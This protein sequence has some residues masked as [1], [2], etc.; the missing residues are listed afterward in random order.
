MSAGVAFAS[1]GDVVRAIGSA[2]EVAFAAYLLNPTGSVARGLEAAAD[3]GASVS[4]TLEAFADRPPAN[5]LRRLAER[6]A[7]D[8]RAH[9]VDVRLGVPGGDTVHLK[10]AVVDGTAFLDDRNWSAA[11]ETIV[12]T[13]RPAE[14]AAVRAAIDGTTGRA[15]DLATEKEP[16]LELEAE[17][18]RSGGGDTIDVETESFGACAVSAALRARAQAGDHVRLLVSGRIASARRSVRERALLRRLAAAGVEV[19]TTEANEKLC[20]AGDRGWV[21]SANATFDLVPTTD[22]GL[23]T[24]DPAL[25]AQLAATFAREWNVARPFH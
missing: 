2:R 11:G 25:L 10:A 19:R 15:G 12:A 22:W 24:S 1:P 14:V 3:R 4:V 13:T 5:A 18:I 7:R 23:A 17:A 6:T 8:L 20:V 21:G 9:G 16:A